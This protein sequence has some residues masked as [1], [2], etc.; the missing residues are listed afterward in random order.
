MKKPKEKVIERYEKNGK[1]VKRLYN[2]LA[3]LRREKAKIDVKI[4][5]LERKIGE[6]QRA[7]LDWYE[8]DYVD[9]IDERVRLIYLHN[10]L[11]IAEGD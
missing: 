5:E 1:E 7:E 4:R 6:I 9:E 8:S 2:G 11:D 3:E 10:Y